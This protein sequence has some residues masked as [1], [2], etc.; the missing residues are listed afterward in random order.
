MNR[1]QRRSQSR[2]KSNTRIAGVTYLAVAGLAGG[3]LGITNP[4]QAAPALITNCTELETQLNNAYTLGGVI[5]ANFSGTCDFAEGFIFGGETKI[6][7]PADRSLTLRFGNSATTGFS[8]QGNLNVSN[9][10][11]TRSSNSTGLSNFIYAFNP[12]GSPYPIVTVSN[13]TFSN[14]NLIAAIYAEG[15]LTVED[16]AFTNLTTNLGAIYASSTT[17]ISNSTFNSNSSIGSGGAISASSSITVT[18]S[19]F[20]SNSSTGPGG[21]ISTGGS[22]DITNSTFNSNSATAGEGGA[23]F[24]DGNIEGALSVSNSTF[25]SNS[26]LSSGGAIS[27]YSP[28]TLTG[29][30]FNS[31]VV[32]DSNSGGGAIFGYRDVTVTDSAFNSNT[33]PGFG[34]AVISYGTFA[35]T[36]SS[37]ISNLSHGG[38]GAVYG[39]GEMAVQNSTFS[40]NRADGFYGGAILSAASTLTTNNSTFVNNQAA[41]A[42]AIFS[43]GGTISNSTFWNNIGTSGASVE[44]VSGYLFANILANSSDSSPVVANG[45][46]NDLGANLFTGDSF[47]VTTT[48]EGASSRTSIDDLVLSSLALNQTGPTNTGTTKTVAIGP[49]SIAKDYYSASSPGALDGVTRNNLATTDQR[50]AQRPNGSGYDVG[51]FETDGTASPSPSASPSSSPSSSPSPSPSPSS[52]P[53]LVV[54]KTIAKQSVAFFPNSSKLTPSAKRQLRKLAIEIRS[55]GLNK[56]NL[57]GFTSTVTN[58]AQSGNSFRKSLSTARTSAVEAYLKA[59]FKKLGHVVKFTKSPKGVANPVKSN[60]SENGR[61]LNRRVEIVIDK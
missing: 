3:S 17:N 12:A 58:A 28:L 48:G 1:K 31:N 44:L 35:I 49:D 5:D 43:E 11:F 9:L 38:G 16:S 45:G 36:N 54:K 33:A 21:A 32:R 56:V 4:A 61:K 41:N 24:F 14:A 10:N 34:G 42:G 55:K 47:A 40:E 39:S 46:I 57:Y 13:T 8:A 23:I 18:N 6:T 29:S 50:G 37:F 51:A 53:G 20:D 25:N 30:T 26:A 59:Q 52:S 7:G 60:N 2:S 19:T 27:T 15:Q 22:L